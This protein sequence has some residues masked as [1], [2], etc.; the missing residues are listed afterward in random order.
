M[1]CAALAVADDHSVQRTKFANG[2]I[3]TVNFGGQL[4][5]AEDGTVF[6]PLSCRV[7]GMERD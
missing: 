2:V 4:Y 5:H 1:R 3:V 6:G 7:H